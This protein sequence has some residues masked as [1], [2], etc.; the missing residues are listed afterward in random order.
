MVTLDPASDLENHHR[1]QHYHH[2]LL[3]KNYICTGRLTD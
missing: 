3:K 1:Y 2:E